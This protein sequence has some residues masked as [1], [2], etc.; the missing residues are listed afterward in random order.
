MTR[1]LRRWQSLAKTYGS[2]S[3]ILEARLQRCLAGIEVA[4]REAADIAEASSRLFG[5]GAAMMTRFQHVQATYLR[6]AEMLRREA[7][8][9]RQSWISARQKEK[10]AQ[11]RVNR[12][13]DEIAKSAATPDA[14]VVILA[15]D[16]GSLAQGSQD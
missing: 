13:A 15:G 10:I 2:M 8:A 4:D 12:I 1:D 5:T 9:V 16:A 11:R 3:R 14:M 7:G 6:K